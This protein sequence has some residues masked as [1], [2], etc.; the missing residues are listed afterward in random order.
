SES[1]PRKYFSTAAIFSDP[2][3]FALGDM[4]KMLLFTV[5]SFIISTVYRKGSISKSRFSEGFC[6]CCYERTR[7]F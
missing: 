2:D 3:T 4:K 6:F 1:S 7:T 5:N